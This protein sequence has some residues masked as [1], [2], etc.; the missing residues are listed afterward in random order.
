MGRFEAF[1]LEL[2]EKIRLLDLSHG[3][4]SSGKNKT[5]IPMKV[6]EKEPGKSKNTT[7]VNSDV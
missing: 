6:L 1:R 4:I 7:A 5:N 3:V 2:S